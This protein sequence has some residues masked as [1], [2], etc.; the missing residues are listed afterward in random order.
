MTLIDLDETVP[1]SSP[2]GG[3]GRRAVAGALALVVAG[4]VIGGFTT[5]RWLQ[6]RERGAKEAAV[7]VTLL[8]GPAGLPS[9]DLVTGQVIDG[10]PTK[11]EI[12]TSL[13]V[14]DAGP[15][16]IRINGVRIE[17]RGIAMHDVWWL[18]ADQM[19]APGGIATAKMTGSIDCDDD[20]LA[21]T[22]TVPA[23]V[24]LTTADGVHRR[25]TAAVDG[26]AWA[27]QVF[28]ACAALGTR[29]PNQFEH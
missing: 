10:R 11:V 27:E 6:Q 22:G 18:P 26:T 21:D 25:A 15:A 14:I 20:P 4:G 23:T 19:V 29:P 28:M 17:Q 24:E 5:Y 13:D 12:T 9:D 2:P 8:S 7:S 1:A 3:T 16:P